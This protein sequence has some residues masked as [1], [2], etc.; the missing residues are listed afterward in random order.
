VNYVWLDVEERRRMAESDFERTHW[1]EQRQFSGKRQKVEEDLCMNQ[2]LFDQGL[3][4]RR[5]Y[6]NRKRDLKKKLLELA[7]FETHE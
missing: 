6:Q 4:K 7:L 2:S 5:H 1:I 3:I